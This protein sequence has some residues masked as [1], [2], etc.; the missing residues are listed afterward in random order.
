MR[1]ENDAAF[2]AARGQ[3]ADH[4][5]HEAARHGV[6][7]RAGLV[8]E[9]DAWAS[10]HRDRDAQL[11]LV[12]TGKR[13]GRL[14]GKGVEVHLLQLALDDPLHQIALRNALDPSVELEVL[15]HGEELEKGIE[16]RAVADSPPDLPLVV[17]DVKACDVRCPRRRRKLARQNAQRGGLSRTVDSQEPEALSARNPEAELPHCHLRPDRR[18]KHLTK[19]SEA[20]HVSVGTAIEHAVGLGRDVFVFVQAA[21]VLRVSRALPEPENHRELQRVLDTERDGEVHDDLDHEIHDVRTHDIQVEWPRHFAELVA[22]LRDDVAILAFVT[23]GELRQ[24]VTKAENRED[25]KDVLEVVVD[26]LRRL[27]QVQH[28]ARDHQA[29]P[30]DEV[31][32]QHHVLRTAVRLESIAQHV[33]KRRGRRAV[34]QEDDGRRRG[35]RVLRVVVDLKGVHLGDAQAGG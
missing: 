21:R 11:P 17:L 24:A 15:P 22:L 25:P 20:H 10:D 8:Q 30:R 12:A 23:D 32:E 7:A 26:R 13:P 5:P 28:E 19:L 29:E 31:E 18:G 27:Q 35:A 1:G 14:V 2:A 33:R 4:V 3:V 6:H 34:E 16:L 9:H